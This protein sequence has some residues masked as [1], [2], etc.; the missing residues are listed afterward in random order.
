MSD[1]FPRR[2]PGVSSRTERSPG[3]S[4]AAINASAFSSK[5]VSTRATLGTVGSMISP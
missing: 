4:S 1:M 2:D 5:K 3:I